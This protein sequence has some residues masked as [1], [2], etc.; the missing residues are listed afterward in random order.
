MISQADG[1]LV[2]S[3]LA[4]GLVV[5]L[6][7]SLLNPG[8]PVADTVAD[9]SARGPAGPSGRLKPEICAPGDGV[10]TASRGGGAQGAVFSGTSSSSP[11]VAGAAALLRQIH[12]GWPAEDIKAALMNTAVLLPLANGAHSPE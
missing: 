6:D 5:R 4:A 12:P 8:D 10:F 2:K 11:H 1:A 7:G 3:N 9:S